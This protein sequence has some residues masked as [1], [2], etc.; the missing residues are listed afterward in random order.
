MD[1]PHGGERKVLCAK[2]MEQ[3]AAILDHALANVGVG[4][5]QVESDTRSLTHATL[6]SAEGV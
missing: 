1:L 5:S 2:L 4:E 6:P 3:A